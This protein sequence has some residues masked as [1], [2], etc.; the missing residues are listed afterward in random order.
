MRKFTP[1]NRK[2]AYITIVAGIG[3]IG[4]TALATDTANSAPLVSIPNTAYCDDPPSRKILTLVLFA[5]P[6][7]GHAWSYVSWNVL[8]GSRA[9]ESHARTRTLC[10]KSPNPAP[11]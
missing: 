3:C 8:T 4:L 2:N 9:A 10:P 5:L 6:L 1:K 7:V 11:K